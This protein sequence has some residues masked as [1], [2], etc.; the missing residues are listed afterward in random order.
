MEPVWGHGKEPTAS[1]AAPGGGRAP[2][3]VQRRG[4]AQGGRGREP[5]CYPGVKKRNQ[6]PRVSSPTSLGSLGL[7][8]AKVAGKERR[9]SEAEHQPRARVPRAPLPA[10]SAGQRCRQVGGQPARAR[11]LGGG[12]LGRGARGPA[13]CVCAETGGNGWGPGPQRP[14]KAT[15]EAERGLSPGP[16]VPV[17]SPPVSESFQGQG[18]SCLK[19]PCRFELA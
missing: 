17:P 12:A 10:G 13:G 9:A 1:V 3:L 15:A 7:S 4:S 16:P 19:P 6:K 14:R 11:R 8:P 18:V 5:L 2:G